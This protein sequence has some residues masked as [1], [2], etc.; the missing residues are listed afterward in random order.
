MG[1]LKVKTVLPFICFPLLSYITFFMWTQS[2]P[3]ISTDN[4]VALQ[5]AFIYATTI[6]CNN[7]SFWGIL[8]FLSILIAIISAIKKLATTYLLLNITLFTIFCLPIF[9]AI[10]GNARFCISFFN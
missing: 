3:G 10:T 2:L 5:Y 4:S 9:L 1:K 7:P 6:A 8:F